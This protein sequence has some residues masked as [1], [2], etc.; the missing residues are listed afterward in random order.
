M[1]R[2]ISLALGLLFTITC[3]ADVPANLKNGHASY[4]DVLSWSKDKI[5]KQAKADSTDDEIKTQLNDFPVEIK[6]K[7]NDINLL[8]IKNTPQCGTINCSYL[9][10]SSTSPTTYRYIS[11]INF[12]AQQSFCY[13]NKNSYLVTSEQET[14]ASGILNLYQLNNQT[15]IRKNS[16][17]IDYSNP[18]QN[19]MAD[20]VWDKSLS[21]QSLLNIFKH[22]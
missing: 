7:C 2:Y 9:V 5:I 4:Q 6:D 18:K 22:Q 8:F 14:N 11:E 15:L 10:F 16:I 13:S 3:Y 21:E 19:K 17:D 20:S 1:N 12:A